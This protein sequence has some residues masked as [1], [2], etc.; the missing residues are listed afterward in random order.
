MQTLSLPNVRAFRV[1]EP[2]PVTCVSRSDKEL[3]NQA[4][5][6]LKSWVKENTNQSTSGR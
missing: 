4:H 1:E 6:W 2:D 3:R 5:K